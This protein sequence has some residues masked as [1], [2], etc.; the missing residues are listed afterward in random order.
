MERKKNKVLILG[1]AGYVG[2]HTN[3][4]LNKN[5]VETCVLDNLST[6][7]REFVK[8]GEFFE[9]DLNDD[10]ILN[11][12]FSSY[13][14]TSVM[15][16]ANFTDFSAAKSNPEAYYEKN[17][18]NLLRLLNVMKKYHVENLVLSFSNDL[19]L[20]SS[21]K[22]F[23]NYENFNAIKVLEASKLI[24]EQILQEY[25]KHYNIKHLILKYSNAA[26]ADPDLEIGEWR[27]PEIHIIPLILDSVF[28]NLN[29]STEINAAILQKPIC[30]IDD[31][32]HVSDLANAH[33]LALKKLL[34][35]RNSEKILLKNNILFKIK[36]II[37]T[38]M[39]ISKKSI[40]LSIFNN[41]ISIENW[42]CNK[43]K[44]K[45]KALNWTPEHS[46]LENII[47]T[48]WNWRIKRDKRHLRVA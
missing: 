48:A 8:W 37:D 24:I 23:T 7:R 32:I 36:D 21:K 45:N 16:F 27:Q 40:D 1:G 22:Y 4:I 2:S 34:K 20:F 31:Y 10:F 15:H 5:G 42:N 9:G 46:S 25:D 38:V 41:I 33:F 47:Y 44:K 11:R 43:L 6:G 13:N 35:K 29:K 28:N 14:I 3:K 18:D 19:N 12:I 39:G 26:G 17:I 30:N